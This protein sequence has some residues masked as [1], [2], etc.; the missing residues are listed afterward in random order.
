MVSIAGDIELKTL[1]VQPMTLWIQQADK[2]YLP[3]NGY[4]HTAR[5]LGADG[6]FSRYQLTFAS[7]M[8]FL[9]LRN[10]MLITDILELSDR[11]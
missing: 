11:V 8:H 1:I 3:V 7:W 9:R 5:R 10:D 6:S 2:S 4:I